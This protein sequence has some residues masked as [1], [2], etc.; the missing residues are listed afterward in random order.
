MKKLLI[1]L[2]SLAALGANAQSADEVI[3]KYTAN[4]GG[5]EA[6][7]KISSAKMTGT[8]SSQG[9]DFPLTTLILNGK[10]MRTDVDV[11]GQFVTNCYFDG[12]G[13]KINPY[14]GAPAATD[15]T[16]T[17]LSDFKAQSYLA[18]QLMDYKARGHK[19]ESPLEATVDGI[20]TYSIKLTN[21]DDGKAT[22]Y[23][24]SK[25]DYV[26]I[27][28]STNRDIQGQNKE[29]ETYYSDL[30]DFAGVKFFMDRSSKIDGQE[31]QNIRFD[32]IELNVPIDEKI[33]NK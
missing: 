6:I 27:K 32:K 7:N 22:N 26:L 31:F 30:K 18:N 13:W 10:G 4:M 3:Q 5:L 19:V 29:V 20:K 14:A 23:F 8:F 17:E 28:S 24:I 21:K 25:T 33:F 12:K 15:V 16:G 11:M 9:N 1:A 2:F